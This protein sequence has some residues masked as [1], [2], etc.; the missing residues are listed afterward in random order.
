MKVRTLIPVDAH[1]GMNSKGHPIFERKPAGWLIDD[2]DCYLLVRNGV[3]EPA[4]EECELKCES[5][6]NR[7]SKDF[8]QANYD[9]ACCA[10]TTGNSL[11][12]SD[13]G[14]PESLERMKTRLKKHNV[15]FKSNDPPEVMKKHLKLVKKLKVKANERLERD[16]KRKMSAKIQNTDAPGSGSGDQDSDGLGS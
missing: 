15:T 6:W 11:Y 7:D 9:Q 13:T 5:F 16:A 8:L 12:D 3:A 2:P 1:V 14:E 4:D 10:H